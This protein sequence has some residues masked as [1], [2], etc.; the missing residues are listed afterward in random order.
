VSRRTGE[1]FSK[2]KTFGKAKVVKSGFK[3]TAKK[4]EGES[5][6]KTRGIGAVSGGGTTAIVGVGTR[7]VTSPKGVIIEVDQAKTTQQLMKEKKQTGTILRNKQIQIQVAREKQRL[8]RQG[9]KP[10]FEKGRPTGR[11]IKEI[12]T[13]TP[14]KDARPI[15]EELTMIK[16]QTKKDARPIIAKLS[17]EKK[18]NAFKERVL[19]L[20][21]KEKEKSKRVKASTELFRAIPGLKKDSYVQKAS[22]YALA[23]PTLATVGLADNIMLSG[24]KV[25]A[26]IEGLSLSKKNTIDELK[27]AGKETPK[28][29]KKTFDPR[30]PEGLINLLTLISGAKLAKSK[31]YSPKGKVS[32]VSKPTITKNKLGTKIKTQT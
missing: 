19:K 24:G 7:T 18:I 10:V 20:L 4:G 30:N 27:R 13:K 22:R 17:E 32:Q 5:I 3:D 23:L 16:K 9:F 28:E 25:A 8:I 26:T 31:A 6:S 12:K 2:T 1:S 14:Q 21:K 15:I 29:V 11:Y